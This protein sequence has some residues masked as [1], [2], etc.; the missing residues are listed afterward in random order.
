LLNKNTAKYA[1]HKNDFDHL[2]QISNNIQI[3]QTLDD[4]SKVSNLKWYKENTDAG[5]KYNKAIQKVIFEDSVPS[6]VLIVVGLADA[7]LIC[8]ISQCMRDGWIDKH[9]AN[10]LALGK[11]AYGKTYDHYIIPIQW[12]WTI[13]F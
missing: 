3:I 1:K 8:N 4:E 9:V 6:D 10:T 12:F 11:S 7:I 13:N 2:L 5:K